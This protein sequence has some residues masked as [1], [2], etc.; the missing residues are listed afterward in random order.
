MC[1]AINHLLV[2]FPS[3]A[4]QHMLKLEK[5]LPMLTLALMMNR[6]VFIKF[7]W[8]FSAYQKVDMRTLTFDVPPQEVNIIFC[9]Y[10]LFIFRELYAPF[11]FSLKLFWVFIFIELS[12]LRFKKWSILTGKAFREQ[13]LCYR[14]WGTGS[15]VPWGWH[16]IWTS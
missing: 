13:V 4:T 9:M 6:A 16:C 2:K 8:C 7:A 14:D 12:Q 5:A 3:S 10:Y 15:Q 1:S 11:I